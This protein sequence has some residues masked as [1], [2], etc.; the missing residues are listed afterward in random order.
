MAGLRAK[1]IISVNKDKSAP[2]NAIA[3][4]AIIGDADSILRSMFESLEE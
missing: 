4:K 3:D 1:R 2:L